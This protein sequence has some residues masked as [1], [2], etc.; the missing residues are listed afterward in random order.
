MLEKYYKYKIDYNDYVVLV[1]A[2]NF[3]E[4]FGNDALVLN[5]LLNY[6]IKLFKNTLKVG[7]PVNGIESIKDILKI[8][9]I[10]YMVIND[11]KP[12]LTNFDYK[13]LYNNYIFNTEL[14]YYNL[15]RIEKIY[16]SLT[17]NIT[18]SNINNIL[19]NIENVIS[20]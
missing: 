14:I 9:N 7:F 18:S 17:E 16:K 2:G 4:C 6:K 3:Y 8:H 20:E 11:D 5:K 10:Y 19:N 1:K 12:I 15:M 13:N